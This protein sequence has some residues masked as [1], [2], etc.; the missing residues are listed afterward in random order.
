MKGA[1]KDELMGM[2]RFGAEII[3][4][5]DGAAITD[6][7]IDA[8]IKRGGEKATE[9]QAKIQADCQH[10]LKVSVQLYK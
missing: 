1:A 6:A 10:S 4:K 2:I 9:L 3:L 7:D 5:S 8:L